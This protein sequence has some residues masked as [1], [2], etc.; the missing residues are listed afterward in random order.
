MQLNP[1]ETGSTIFRRSRTVD[2]PH[3]DIL[4]GSQVIHSYNSLN[5]LGKT[6]D[7]KLTFEN[8]IKNT[9]SLIPQKSGLLRKSR[10]IFNS[11]NIVVN[12]FY[13]ILTFFPR[14]AALSLSNGRYFDLAFLSDS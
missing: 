7:S 9:A 5:L 1:A 8:P 6:L 10:A 3:P 11:D 4:I 2:P 14:L 12:I 13:F